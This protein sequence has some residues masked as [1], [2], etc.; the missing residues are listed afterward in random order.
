MRLSVV[1]QVSAPHIKTVFISKILTLMLA[2]NCFGFRM[3]FNCRNIVLAL[4]MRAVIYAS[5]SSCLPLKLLLWY[6]N[7]STPTAPIISIIELVHA[8]FYLLNLLFPLRV[9]RPTA[10]CRGCCYAVRLHLH[11]LLSV[12]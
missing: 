11:L 8:V 4:T 3:Y 2:D 10:G 5:H 9:L 1:L 6:V 7:V 12:G